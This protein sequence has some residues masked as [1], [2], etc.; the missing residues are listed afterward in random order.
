MAPYAGMGDLQTTSTNVVAMLPWDQ[1]LRRS[2]NRSHVIKLLD[3]PNAED[4]IQG[5]G[6]LEVYQAVKELGPHDASPV[7]GLMTTSQIK[8]LLDIDVWHGHC[9]DISDTLIWLSAFR[10][11]GID[12]FIRAARALDQEALS[13][14]LIRRLH[15]TLTQRDDAS[16]EAPVPEWV[17]NPPPELEP[18]VTTM[19]G[20]F[21]IA[22][23]LTDEWGQ[24]EDVPVDEDERKA[25]LQLVSDLYR[26]EDWA[27]I[28]DM[29]RAAESDLAS[30]LQEDALRFRDAR[31][32]D[33]GFPPLMR[34]LQVYGLMNVDVLEKPSST[35]Y[36]LLDELLPAR[37]AA[38]FAEGLFHEA[39]SQL[40]RPQDVQRIE[41]DLVPLANSALV[42]DGAELGALEELKDTL[43]RAK[44]YIE[45]ALAYGAEGTQEIL[46]A[47]VHRLA[48]HHVTVLFRVGYTLT[49]KAAT[50][51]R[52]LAALDC[53]EQDGLPMGRLEESERISLDGL[54]AKRPRFCEA[55]NPLSADLQ[56]ASAGPTWR[57]D[58][59]APEEPRAF[60]QASDLD[61]VNLMLG[62][63][64]GL[65]LAMHARR[66]ELQTASAG[67]ANLPTEERTAQ[68]FVTTAA[69]HVLLGAAPAAT[70]IKASQLGALAKLLAEDAFEGAKVLDAVCGW[71]GTGEAAIARRVRIGLEDLAEVL[72]P[73]AGTPI[74]P[75]F[76]SGLLVQA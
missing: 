62:D 7:L 27:Y 8:A 6:P 65:S 60:A 25:I 74:D 53:F 66:A 36:P 17:S 15:V 56:A 48:H 39:M 19:D 24:A 59:E 61:A 9:L 1:T 21:I 47:A 28:A 20:R 73:L 4:L 13:L 50:R 32:E 33:L 55:L 68:V 37:Y 51:A 18:L 34:A 10:E 44:G 29:L 49:V 11:C 40:E 57:L 23:R 5:L 30:T 71:F 70:P 52:A 63:L 35:E 3:A 43:L 76:L 54:R 45:L 69:A 22:A 67:D 75:R 42:A 64:E 14:L 41:G 38:A 12:E 16:E 46:E 2:A 31:M 72:R 26:D 58:P